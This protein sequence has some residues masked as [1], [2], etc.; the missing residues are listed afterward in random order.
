VLEPDVFIQV[1]RGPEVDELD[2]GVART[3]AIDTSEALDDAD[4]IPVDVVIDQIVAVLKVLS[5]GDAVRG[6]EQVDA[7]LLWQGV[8]LLAMLGARGEVDQDMIKVRLTFK[9]CRSVGRPILLGPADKGTV[10]PM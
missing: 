5:F 9:P 7:A 2:G 8:Q 4:G 10:N 3:D 1:I 6:D